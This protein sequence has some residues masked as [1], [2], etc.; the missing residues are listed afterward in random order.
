[1]K[2]ATERKRG[3]ETNQ[4]RNLKTSAFAHAPLEGIR[5]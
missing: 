2:L 3:V 5:Q 1:M 4:Y